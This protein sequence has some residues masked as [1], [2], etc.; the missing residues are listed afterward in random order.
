MTKRVEFE[1][2]SGNVFEDLNLPKADERLFKAQIAEK[3]HDIIIERD[4]DQKTAGALLGID[5]PK[6]SALINGRLSGFTID[7]LF[8]FLLALDQS[9]EVR[10]TSKK[11]KDA[12]AELKLYS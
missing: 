4:L 1:K 3:I 9:I 6:V 2:S 7:R 10:V 11:K 5:Q 8:R 12:V